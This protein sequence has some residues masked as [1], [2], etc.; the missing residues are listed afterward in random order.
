MTLTFFGHVGFNCFQWSEHQLAQQPGR[1]RISVVE[2]SA[3]R[4]ASEASASTTIELVLP[5]EAMGLLTDKTNEFGVH[6]AIN[7]G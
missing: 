2:L 1:R 6:P 3:A 5:D 4:G 7:L